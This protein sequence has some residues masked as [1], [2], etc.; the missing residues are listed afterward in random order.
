MYVYIRM[1][2]KY[3][4]VYMYICI[5]L[6]FVPGYYFF[7]FILDG[8]HMSNS[9]FDHRLLVDKHLE[10]ATFMWNHP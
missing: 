7:V 10:D 8:L 3:M 5:L 4:Y 1:Y 2:V 6:A 9:S